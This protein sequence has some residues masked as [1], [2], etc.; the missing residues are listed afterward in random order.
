M[1]AEGSNG[2]LIMTAGGFSVNHPDLIVALAP[3]YKLPG[4]YPFRPDPAPRM[5]SAPAGRPASSIMPS[6]VIVACRRAGED[7]ERLRHRSP[8]AD[9]LARKKGV[10]FLNRV[11]YVA[12]RRGE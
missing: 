10:C 1:C 12:G 7:V 4:V 8:S 3:R 11:R 9:F 2:G 5:A 6:W